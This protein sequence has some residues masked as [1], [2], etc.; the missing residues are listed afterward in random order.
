[1]KDSVLRPRQQFVREAALE[2]TRYAIRLRVRWFPVPFIALAIFL[3]GSSAVGAQD[4]RARG[5]LQGALVLTIQPE[6]EITFHSRINPPLGGTGLGAAAS[7][8]YFITPAL[9]LEGGV[10]FVGGI[11]T[12][13]VFSYMDDRDEYTS[14]FTVVS[15]NGLLRWKPRGTSAVEL[16][17]GGG[18]AGTRFATHDGVHNSLFSGQQTPLQETSSTEWVPN[19]TGGA[20][21]VLPTGSKVA[22]VGSVRTRWRAGVNVDAYNG[23]SRFALD[24]GVGLRVRF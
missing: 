12:E 10:L 19:V 13:Q 21:V 15:M 2:M 8:G 7:A 9:A 16:V 6:G 22:F 17:V 24:M 18:V 23:V 5:Y 14:T 1:M 4:S 20:D 11:S 3:T